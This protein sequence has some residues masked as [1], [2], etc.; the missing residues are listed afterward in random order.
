MKYIIPFVFLVLLTLSCKKEEESNILWETS[1]GQGNAFFVEATAD[2]GLISCGTLLGKAYLVKFTSGKIT[3]AEYIS[4][5]TGS[6]TSAISSGTGYFAAGSS[7][8]KML[9]AQIGIDGEK[10]WEKTITAGFFL[11][12]A[13]LLDEGDG[14]FLAVGS[15][16]PD[17]TENTDAEILF[18]RF[19]SS[20]Q[21]LEKDS[22]ETGFASAN[23]AC[24]DN[25]GNIY[26]AV[27]KKSGSQKPKALIIKYNSDLQKLWETE[28]YN[29]PDFSASCLD[30]A[31]DGSGNIFVSGRTEASGLSGTLSNSF[32]ASVNRNGIVNW[33]KYMENSNSGS[34]VILK[35]DEEAYML[36]RNCL[37]IS[38]ADCSTGSLTG[39]IRMFNQCDS[40]TTDAFG[41]CI[42]IAKCGNILAA[43]SLD[44]NFYLALKCSQ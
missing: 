18:V 34:S 9:L 28:L 39:T 6:F 19:D 5:S 11:D 15:A 2:S 32:L 44:G 21:V 26:L 35:G 29:N 4:E 31:A 33:K 20:G 43:G 14:V 16:S 37:V 12:I 30:A 3:E 36:N 8:G 23:S 25:L 7:A 13:T 38:K 40:Y 10:M 17:S 27:T 1:L 42:S 41:N 24:S 22:V